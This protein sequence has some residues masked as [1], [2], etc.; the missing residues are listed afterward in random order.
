M[1]APAYGIIETRC[2]L[3]VAGWLLAAGCWLLLIAAGMCWTA[4]PA[5]LSMPD[6]PR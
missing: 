4:P 3:L 1:A 5:M 2:W 6:A